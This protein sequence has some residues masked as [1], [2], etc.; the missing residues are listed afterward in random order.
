MNEDYPVGV[1]EDKNG[2]LH[3]DVPAILKSMGLPD[4]P[5]TREEFTES[6]TKAI[7]K[8]VPD[9]KLTID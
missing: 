1:S 4:T 6:I 8:L 2:A 9:A 5:E 3:F 7:R